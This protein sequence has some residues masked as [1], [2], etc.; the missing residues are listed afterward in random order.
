MNKEEHSKLHKDKLGLDIPEDYFVNSKKDILKTV[1]TKA[2]T[3]LVFGLKPVIAYSLAAS[4]V[5]LITFSIWMRMSFSPLEHEVTDMETSELSVYSNDVL[6]SSLLI[7]DS[8]MEAFVDEY[9]LEEIFVETELSELELE[10]AF[11]NSL[12]V[13]DSLVDDY[14]D[15]QLIENIIL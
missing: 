4:L 13:E 6:V 12:F 8:E 14:V 5:L 15:K 2:A 9:I 1:S 7:D 10:D 3:K 11:M